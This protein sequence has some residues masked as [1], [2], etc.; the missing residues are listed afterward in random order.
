M[1]LSRHVSAILVAAAIAAL[2]PT[3]VSAEEC[4][5]EVQPELDR[6]RVRQEVREMDFAVEVYT[7]EP[8]A[9]VDVDFI[10]T[11]RLFDGEEITTT[12]R[13]R[14]KVKTSA[15]FN[16]TAQFAYDSTVVDWRFKVARC[17]VCGT[18]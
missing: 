1:R 6:D 2:P 17:V 3:L 9:E 15:R 7:T 13:R 11:E 10:S 8:C 4:S 16:I 12:H 14:L 5:A 18:V